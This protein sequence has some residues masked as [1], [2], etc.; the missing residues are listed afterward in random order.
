MN[1]ET[2][3]QGR[4]TGEERVLDIME[5]VC[6]EWFRRWA[7]LSHEFPQRRRRWFR[8]ADLEHEVLHSW[9]LVEKHIAGAMAVGCLIK[10]PG[11]RLYRWNEER[12][13]LSEYLEER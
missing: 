4:P 1:I 2:E 8:P 11:E 3:S 10:K 9:G 5:F 7:V 6:G 12:F 13:P